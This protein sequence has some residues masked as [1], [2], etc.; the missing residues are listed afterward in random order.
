M[1]T[2]IFDYYPPTPGGY[3]VGTC[4]RTRKV[5]WISPVTRAVIATGKGLADLGR[6]AAFSAIRMPDN[7]LHLSIFTETPDAW[8]SI[9]NGNSARAFVPAQLIGLAPKLAKWGAGGQSTWMNGQRMLVILDKITP[10]WGLTT[11]DIRSIIAN[12][13]MSLL[14]LTSETTAMLLR[15]QLTGYARIKSVFG[16]G[17]NEVS[18]P[19][20]PFSP[21]PGQ[22]A[23]RNQRQWDSFTTTTWSTGTERM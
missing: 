16:E 4:D 1:S 18:P 9:T 6:T 22:F 8:S 14:A 5:V 13:A 23:M 2:S 17:A 21:G 15:Q 7:C 10:E 19:P 20:P 12:P 11:E 3:L